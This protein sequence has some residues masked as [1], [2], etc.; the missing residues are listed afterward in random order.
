MT[1]MT[2]YSRAIVRDLGVVINDH[3]VIILPKNIILAKKQIG[4]QTLFLITRHIL[5]KCIVQSKRQYKTHS[6]TFDN[7]SNRRKPKPYTNH[8]KSVMI[9]WNH[10]TIIQMNKKGILLGAITP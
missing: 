5:S 9:P 7:V 2:D 4:E 8:S 3:S 10:L 6:R 1:A